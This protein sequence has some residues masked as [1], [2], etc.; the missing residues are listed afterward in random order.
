MV[1]ARPTAV[2]STPAS[3]TSWTEDVEAYLRGAASGSGSCAARMISYHMGWV[4]AEGRPAQATG[5]HVRSNLCCWAAEACGATGRDAVP[6]AAA[7][8]L[9]H[10]FTLVHDDIQDGDRTRRGRP[11]VWSIWGEAQAINAGDVLFALAAQTAL[12]PGGET[13]RRTEAARV[14]FDA[15]IRIIDGQVMDLQHEGAVEAGLDGYVGIVQAKTAALVGAALEAGAV[16]AGADGDLR[17]SLRNAGRQ[18]GLAFQIRD[19]WL[20]VWGATAVTGKSRQ[21]DLERRKLT[22]PVLAAYEAADPVRRDRLVALFRTRG[23][24]GEGEIRRVLDDLGASESTTGAATARAFAAIDEIQRADLS[25]AAKA[26]FE[27]V[28]RYVVDRSS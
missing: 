10:N 22:Y 27:R 6:V 9:I 13:S 20:G 21:S 7:T 19:D 4:D 23:S 24:D 8:E 3:L 2:R 5:K 26:E 17:T 1:T 25:P 18:L 28:A 11:T 12:G 14:L 15:T 16:M